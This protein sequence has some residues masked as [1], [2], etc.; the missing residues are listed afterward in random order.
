M[1]AE[2]ANDG[3]NVIINGRTIIAEGDPECAAGI[4]G[5]LGGKGGKLCINNGMVTATGKIGI[6]GGDSSFDTPNPNGG[7][8]VVYGGTVTAIGGLDGV[9]SNTNLIASPIAGKQIEVKVGND[10]ASETI[11]QGSPFTEP[12]TI[13]NFATDYPYFHSET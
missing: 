5:G 13:T 11:V 7:D 4:G 12:T 6:G 8:L 2:N 3:G 9:K 1:T 10:E